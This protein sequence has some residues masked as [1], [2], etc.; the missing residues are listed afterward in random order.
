MLLFEGQTY[1][2]ASKKKGRGAATT[3]TTTHQCFLYWKVLRVFTTDM[4]P[5]CHLISMTSNGP[6][7]G[8]SVIQRVCVSCFPSSSQEFFASSEMNRFSAKQSPCRLVVVVVLLHLPQWAATGQLVRERETLGWLTG[9]LAVCLA[10]Q[11]CVKL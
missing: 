9:W 10:V 6:L 7:C 8:Q 3:T 1:L 2:F 4:T 5:I 11:E